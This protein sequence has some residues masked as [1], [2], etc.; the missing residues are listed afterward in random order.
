MGKTLAESIL[1][2]KAGT[3]VKAGDIVVTPV[4]L[5]FAQDG[6]A[7]LAIKQFQAC[8]FDHLANPAATIFFLDHNAPTPTKELS[9]DHLLIR[10]FARETGARLS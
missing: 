3:D 7:P 8:G 10:D 5:V 6:T 4:D 2:E 1:S 9:N